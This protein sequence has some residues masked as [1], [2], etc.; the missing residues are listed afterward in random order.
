MKRLADQHGESSRQVARA[1]I[2]TARFLHSVGQTEAARRWLERSLAIEESAAGHEW[3]AAIE[4]AGALPHLERAAALYPPKSMEAAR[5]HTRLANWYEAHQAPKPA[6]DEYRAAVAVYDKLLLLPSNNKVAATGLAVALND[7]GLALESGA[8]NFAESERLYR[9]ALAIQ[10]RE[11]GPR[12]A[13]TGITLNNLAGA[14]G[15]QGRLAEAEPLL[16]RALSVLDAAL[17]PK[18]A[19]SANTASNLA[20]LLAALGRA[21]EAAPLYRRA[22]E[23]FEAAGDTASARQVREAAEAAASRRR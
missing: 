10:Q 2:D 18:H 22:V 12:H 1:A 16:R 7:L 11:L 13:E 6:I 3:M 23:A 17:G 20:D 8:E 4:P 14:V 19:K 5:A 21:G 9:R 15:A